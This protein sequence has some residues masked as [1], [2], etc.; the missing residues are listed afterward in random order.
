MYS[1]PSPQATI[2][3]LKNSTHLGASLQNFSLFVLFSFSLQLCVLYML[4][5]EI[6][7]LAFSIHKKV[8]MGAI[9]RC[10]GV[11]GPLGVD[12]LRFILKS[13]MEQQNIPAETQ[14]RNK[15][16]KST[17]PY[18]SSV[19]T[20]KR[21]ASPFSSVNATPQSFILV[22]IY[23]DVSKLDIWL[24]FN[25]TSCVPAAAKYAKLLIANLYPNDQDF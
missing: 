22:Q 23:L 21:A 9:S 16:T 1:T 15:K 13:D 14:C 2:N 7:R 20:Q 10:V 24:Q 17:P 18:Q 4:T 5:K 25:V 6:N 11:W 8:T 12:K 19:G 3:K